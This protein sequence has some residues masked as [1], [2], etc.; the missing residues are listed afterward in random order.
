MEQ[1]GLSQGVKRF[2]NKK[3]F[4]DAQS[5]PEAFYLEEKPVSQISALRA[6]SF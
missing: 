6:N 3:C 2:V 1:K 5:V 4:R